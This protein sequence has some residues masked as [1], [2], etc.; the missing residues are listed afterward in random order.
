MKLYI[1][2][3]VRLPIIRSL[4]TV[5][6][7]MVYVILKFHKRVRITNIYNFRFSP[8]TFKFN[9]FLLAD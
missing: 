8:C 5:H 4:F 6:S 2:Q 1:F 9:H 7:A 3:T